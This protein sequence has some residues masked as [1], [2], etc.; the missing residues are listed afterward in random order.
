MSKGEDSTGVPV[1]RSSIPVPEDPPV[2]FLEGEAVDSHH[3]STQASRVKTAQ[4]KRTP[5][6]SPSKPATRL[7]SPSPQVTNPHRHSPYLHNK[8]QETV[9][10]VVS[11]RKTKARL[12]PSPFN[13]AS[14]S[15]LASPDQPHS[16]ADKVLHLERKL[17]ESNEKYRHLERQYHDLLTKHVRME[18][19]YEEEKQ[20]QNSARTQSPE[21]TISHKDPNLASDGSVEALLRRVLSELRELKDRMTRIEKATAKIGK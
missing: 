15:L 11:E 14:T 8:A 5:I 17:S 2:I 3:V 18:Q 20:G 21:E 9:L 1:S 12:S 10:N 7:F 16:A 19:M 6:T 13:S 4:S